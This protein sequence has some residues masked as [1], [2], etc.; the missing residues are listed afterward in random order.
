M[1]GW[2]PVIE[3]GAFS[4]ASADEA[5]ACLELCGGAFPEALVEDLNQ[6][7]RVTNYDAN[8]VPCLTES[9]LCSLTIAETTPISEREEVRLGRRC[10]PTTPSN[11]NGAMA[12]ARSR[13]TGAFKGQRKNVR[14]HENG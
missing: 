12:H 7:P 14:Y 10:P 8:M 11:G 6:C 3:S 1:P 13:P 4:F 2:K 5:R 9:N